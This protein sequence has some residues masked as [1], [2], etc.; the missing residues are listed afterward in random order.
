VVSST[1]KFL[2]GHSDVTGGVVVA[3]DQALL[4][5]LAFHRNAEG[6]ALAPFE[7]WLLLRGLKTLPLRLERQSATAAT[8]ARWLAARHGIDSVFYPGLCGHPGHCVHRRQ[9]S[10]D[11]AVLSFA[12]GDAARSRRLVEATRVFDLAVSFGSVSSAISLPCRMSHA[13]IPA[14]LRARLAP[15][16]DLVR[17]AVGIESA[18]DL[19]EDLDQALR[20]SG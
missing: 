2:G 4:D 18:D 3:R 9:A 14:E 15:P 12:T 10:G 1:T 7:C 8:L 5:E 19:L 6:T 11:G 17:L 16:P 13:S 20:H